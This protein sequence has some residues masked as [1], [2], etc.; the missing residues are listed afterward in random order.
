MAGTFGSTVAIEFEGPDT[1]GSKPTVVLTTLS[2][3]GNIAGLLDVFTAWYTSDLKGL[4]LAD[5]AVTR[6]VIT[7][8]DSQV[9]D[10]VRVQGTKGGDPAPPQ[11]AVLVHK[12]T[13]LIGRSNRGRTYWPGMLRAADVT[14]GGSIG[15]DVVSNIQE[16]M[17]NLLD[18][19]EDYN[20]SELSIKHRDGS[21][22]IAV[23]QYIVESQIG[24]QRR[25]NRR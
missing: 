7:S 23:I 5:Y 3:D 11:V 15:G 4:L 13:G 9:I 22:D 21:G 17:D 14:G 10:T 1:I 8:G 20:E 25:R 24:T 19:L 2:T 18:A 16:G 12:G 6:T